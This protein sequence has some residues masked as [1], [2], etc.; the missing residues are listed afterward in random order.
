MGVENDI[1]WS[2][3]EW[4]F[5]EP[6]GT[7]PPRIPRSTLLPWGL[8]TLAGLSSLK[9]RWFAYIDEVLKGLWHGCLVEFLDNTSYAYLCAMELEKLPVKDKITASCQ[10][11]YVQYVCIAWFQ[12]YQTTMNFENLFGLQVFKNH[13]CNPFQSSLSL[14]IRFSF[15]ICC[16]IF[17]SFNRFW[18][19][20]FVC[21]TQFGSGFLCLNVD[22]FRDTA[23]L[24]SPSSLL[25]KFP[26]AF[27]KLWT[28]FLFFSGPITNLW[29]LI[30]D[31]VNFADGFIRKVNVGLDRWIRAP[32]TPLYSVSLHLK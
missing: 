26:I 19:V 16:G 6:D 1:F 10:I 27:R 15:C 18:A 17:S 30:Y 25:L 5:G 29:V 4:G 23:S 22:K 32:K 28:L 24:V 31:V 9:K 13:N 3:I 7:P 8:H 12:T 14:S 2:E 21:F 11:L 20:M